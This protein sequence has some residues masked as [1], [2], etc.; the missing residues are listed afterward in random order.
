[1]FAVTHAINKSSRTFRP[2]STG[3]F[4]PPIQRIQNLKHTIP[5]VSHSCLSFLIVE[6]GEKSSSRKFGSWSC[7]LLW[8]WG[9]ARIGLPGRGYCS[10]SVNL[11]R[12]WFFFDTR[13]F[14]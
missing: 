3:L 12:L 8:L 5:S 10:D 7:S 1:M 2:I 4:V 14:V 9:S 11:C 13:Y 6:N